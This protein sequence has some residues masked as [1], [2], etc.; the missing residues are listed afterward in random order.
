MPRRQPRRTVSNL[1]LS[2]CSS[3]HSKRARSDR[4]TLYADVILNPSFPEADFERQQKLQLAAIQREKATP[5]RWRCASFRGCSTAKGTPTQCR[6]PVPEPSESVEKLTREDL[7]KFHQTWF[8]PNNA[9]LIVVGDTTLAEIQPKLENAV[10]RAGSPATCRR[11]TSA[12]YSC[13]TK[14]VVYL[15]DSPGALQSIILAGEIAPPANNRTK[16]RS[17]P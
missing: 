17:K 11:R 16:S 1:D 14:P 5:I 9:T 15:I 12:R 10:R 8:R 13:P 7:V 4:S 2:S 6:S 3:R